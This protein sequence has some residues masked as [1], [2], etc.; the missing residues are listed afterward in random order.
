MLQPP[1]PLLLLLRAF[2]FSPLLSLCVCERVNILCGL[3]FWSCGVVYK[4]Q[5]RMYLPLNYK[6]F[7]LR[8]FRNRKS[9]SNIT[10]YC[11]LSFFPSALVDCTSSSPS[12]FFIFNARALNLKV[13]R[14]TRGKSMR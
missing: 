6:M 4:I 12:L 10:M 5:F 2:F 3:H 14:K 11:F 9:T 7:E 1:P 13:K 8:A